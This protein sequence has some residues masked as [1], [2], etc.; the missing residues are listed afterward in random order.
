M[1]CKCFLMLSKWKQVGNLPLALYRLEL[2]FHK[3]DT[4]L[5]LL[6]FSYI[7]LFIFPV[8]AATVYSLC[9]QVKAIS[10][11]V[12]LEPA[13]WNICLESFQ[14]ATGWAGLMRRQVFFTPICV[15]TERFACVSYLGTSACSWGMISLGRTNP[16]MEETRS[17]LTSGF[18]VVRW[19]TC[20][21]HTKF[22][23]YPIFTFTIEYVLIHSFL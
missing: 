9:H 11:T 20:R 8:S 6:C 18:C 15:K 22:T 3:E 23:G 2:A 1:M 16:K 13:E 10:V 17:V 4:G 7:I 12:I 21:F 19:G 14:L 5:F